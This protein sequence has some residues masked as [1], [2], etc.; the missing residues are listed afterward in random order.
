MAGKNR[1]KKFP[2]AIAVNRRARFDYAIDE[3][4]ECGVVLVGTE[5]KSLRAGKA[6]IAQA[7][8]VVRDG[9]LWLYQAEIPEYSHGNR[10]NHDPQRQRKLLAHRAEVDR[11]EKFTQQRGRTLV[12]LRLYFS[13][14]KA[15]VLIGLGRGKA[16]HDKRHDQAKADAQRD[17]DRALTARQRD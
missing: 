11:M 14:G 5:V 12:P 16:L 2:D 8:A 13:D 7:F 10:F 15:K 3:T 1:K 4:V 17:I 6:S 9:E